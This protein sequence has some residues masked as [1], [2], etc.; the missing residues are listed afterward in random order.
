[1][2]DLFTGIA[3]AQQADVFVGVH[4]ANMANAWLMRP[5]S[6]M[7]E[8]Q[9]FGFDSGAAHLQYPLFNLEVSEAVWRCAWLGWWS[10]SFLLP[11]SLSQH[12][13][14]PTAA[15]SVLPSLRC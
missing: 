4:G 10:T 8:L 9:P 12:G 5:G 1:M 13:I 15:Q 2:A 14:P 11:S 3:A 7:I 6:S